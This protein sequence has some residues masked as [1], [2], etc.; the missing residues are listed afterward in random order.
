MPATPE[1]VFCMT[2]GPSVALEPRDGALLRCPR[3]GAEDQLPNFPLFV[4][5]G[6]SAAG[7][8]TMTELLRSR[9]P[10]CEVFDSDAILQ[11]AA[12][13]WDVWRSTWLRLAHAVALNGRVTV[14]CGSL[15]P[16]QLEALPTRK[17]IGPI[18]FCTLDCPDAVL[19]ERLRAR[20]SWR[21]AGTAAAITEQQRFAAWLRAHIQP[22]YDT[23]VLSPAETAGH[24][25]AWVNQNLDAGAGTGATAAN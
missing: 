24:I 2:C 11:V 6:A 8:T 17:I 21:G 16:S 5:T 13:G 25:A 1:E 23:S 15:L 4:V 10:G 18:H 22:C 12:L 14:L 3:C 7:K 9:L 19:A 20:P